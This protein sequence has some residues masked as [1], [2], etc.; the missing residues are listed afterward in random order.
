M[1]NKKAYGIFLAVQTERKYHMLHKKLLKKL[2]NVNCI[3]IINVSFEPTSQSFYIQIKATKGQ[4]KRC[5]ICG[6]KCN[7]YDT[8]TKC[9]K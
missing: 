3:T 4:Q 7:G 6:R 8:T 2:L 1:H 9:R 5:P